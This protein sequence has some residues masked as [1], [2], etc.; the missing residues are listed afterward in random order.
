MRLERL[1]SAMLGRAAG[2]E[3]AGDLQ[4]RYAA[5]RRLTAAN[6]AALEVL[7]DLQKTASGEFI[8]DNAYIRSASNHAM[9]LAREAVEALSV[10]TGRR[11]ER[12]ER[13]L[14]H[15]AREVE[16]ALGARAETPSGPFVIDF[17]QIPGAAPALVGAKTRRLAEIRAAGVPAPDGFAVTGS[18]CLKL[19]ARDGLWQSIQQSIDS[20]TLVDREGLERTSAGIRRQVLSAAWPP[21]VSDAILEAF[22]RLAAR[23]SAQPALVSVRSSAVGEDEDFSFAGQYVSVLNVGRE[24]LLEACRQV[25]ASQF[26]PRAVVY[27]KS[28]SV[29]GSL[30]PMAIGVVAM[31]EAAASGVLYTF[32]PEAPETETMLVSGTWGLGTTTVGGIA[33]PDIVRL[34][35]REPHEIVESRIAVKKRMLVRRP[36]EGVIEVD[37]PG[38]MQTQPCLTREQLG[39][40]AALAVRMERHFGVPQDIEWAVDSSERVLVLQS[41]PLRVPASRRQGRVVASRKG[42]PLL[43]GGGIVASRGVASGQVRILREKATTEVPRGAVIV[44]RAATTDLAANLDR[45]AAIVTEVGSAASHLA[46]VAREFGIPAIFDAAGALS[47]LKEGAVVTVDAEFG[48]VYEGRIEALLAEAGTARDA[49]LLETPLFRKLRDVSL[50]LTPLTLTD[51]RSRHFRPS[52]CRTLHDILRYAHEVAV[53]RMFLSD[54]TTG[55]T[56]AVRVTT[57]VPIDFRI[58]DLGGG[59]DLAPGAESVTPHQFGSRP[60]VALWKGIAATTWSTAPAAGIGGLGSAIMTSLSS[61][62]ERPEPNFVLVTDEYVNLNVRFGYH[63]SRVDAAITHSPRENY[64]T[65]V[66]HGGAADARGRNRRLDFM[67]AILGG[68]HWHVDRRGDALLARMESLPDADM[69]RE[70]E[71]VGRLLVVT[72]QLD[73]Q[74]VDDRA[75]AAAVGAFLA[76]DDS[77]GLESGQETGE[78]A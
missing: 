14:E 43:L 68:R 16:G 51:P 20:L 6:N 69:V 71:V 30:L 17:A 28:R 46:T 21:D 35:R 47:A 37:V 62:A 22:D 23:R 5:L 11:E 18:A 48:N 42:L 13:A 19:L 50:H 57:K 39:R 32:S 4:T 75:T 1:I 74:L 65:V 60:L 40:L 66:F 27:Y 8:F 59:L 34:S 54:L 63:F 58:I 25:V 41:R 64:A 10:V 72:R 67:E 26:G 36:G 45:A 29:E 49:G 55:R 44:A 33:T 7:S 73:T 77:L 78:D 31:V 12:L 70:M 56:G 76:G 38:W 15:I 3:A 53:Q 2:R 9:E 24:T 61:Q 52:G